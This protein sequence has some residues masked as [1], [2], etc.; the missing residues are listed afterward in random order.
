MPV[1]PPDPSPWSQIVVRTC[2]A[3]EKTIQAGVQLG[4][5]RWIDRYEMWVCLDCYEQSAGGWS[6]EQEARIIAHVRAC[7]RACPERNALGLLSRD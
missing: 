6:A 2:T 5:A 1:E 4:D 3:C 7:R